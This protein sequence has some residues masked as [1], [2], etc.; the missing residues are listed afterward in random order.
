MAQASGEGPVASSL[1]T[2]Q[3]QWFAEHHPG[4]PLPAMRLC[5]AS[6]VLWTLR[7]ES[8]ALIKVSGSLVS[9]PPPPY[10]QHPATLRGR[11]SRASARLTLGE[12]ASHAAS[13]MQ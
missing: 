12:A 6:S 10:A 8:S 5:V 9:C 11:P 4:L 13:A 3:Q 2:H 7:P 1:C